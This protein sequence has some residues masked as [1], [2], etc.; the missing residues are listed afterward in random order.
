MTSANEATSPTAMP[1]TGPLDRPCCGTAGGGAVEV[2]G[3]FDAGAG[4][5]DAVG[6][7]GGGSLG[8][9]CWIATRF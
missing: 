7:F 6:G 3:E 5:P 9:G 4:V 2:I 1:A 8:P